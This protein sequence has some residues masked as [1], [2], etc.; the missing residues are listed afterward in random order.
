M[1][2][3]KGKTISAKTQRVK[4]VALD[5]VMSS[6]AF[7]LFDIF[8]YYY[9]N[10]YHPINGLSAYLGSA[11]LLAEQLTIPVMMLATY[12]LSGYYNIPFNKSRLQE[13]ITT[14][15]SAACNSLLI[16]F[17]LLIN[18]PLVR[19]TE[20][21][22]VI[23]VLFLLLLT[24]TYVGRL[25]L[26]Q[27]AIRQLSRHKWNINTLIVGNSRMARKTA[28]ELSKSTSKLGYNIVGFVRIDG[29]KDADDSKAVFHTDE[30]PDVCRRLHI[31]QL[32]LSPQNL[33]E[34]SAMKL[35]YRLF[36]LNI[37]IKIAPDT[38]SFLTRGIHLQDIYGEPLMDLTS[39]GCSESTK[40]VKRLIDII[41]SSAALILL[42][43]VYLAITVCILVSSGRPVIF[44]QERIG[45]RHKKFNIIKFRTMR[46]DAEKE[47][48]RL[49]SESDPRITPVGHTLRK[50][51]LDELPQFFNVL[52]GD[53]SLVGPRPEREF[54]IEQIVRKAPWF[55]LIHQVRPGITSWG[56]VKYGYASDVDQMV[57]RAR[58]ELIYL[59]NMSLMVDLKIMIY[60][61]KTV[62]TGKGV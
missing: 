39:P 3:T 40:N 24:L 19:R 61:I 42:T 52:K 57:R 26:T 48:P 23:T 62:I 11:K 43:P 51:R 13:L 37:P 28:F 55:S 53:M 36:P 44:L 33:D 46:N 1:N 16:Y 30:L 5:F 2:S 49:S 17:A 12:W 18:D 10:C 31:D 60:T 7:L 32:I 8:R 56:M 27:N 6:V 45:Y 21:Y 59:A 47:G 25:T 4:Y 34:N 15:L 41:L 38:L 58:Y 35:L 22:E 20:S 14:L 54:F 9:F 50:Y 29:E